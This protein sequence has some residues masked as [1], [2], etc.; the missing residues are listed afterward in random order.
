MNE[1]RDGGE[2]PRLYR[3]NSSRGA[4]PH[5]RKDL[6][7]EVNR[8]TEQTEYKGFIIKPN[9]FT[10]QGEKRLIGYTIRKPLSTG[11]VQP[12]CRKSCRKKPGYSE[13]YFRTEQQARQAI[14]DGEIKPY[15]LLE[16]DDFCLA[17]LKKKRA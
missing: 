3:R 17:D 5:R 15:S 11:E 16:N 4:T 2:L 9:T 7:Y 8:M 13:I 10:Y 6:F 14:D 12:Y 1:T